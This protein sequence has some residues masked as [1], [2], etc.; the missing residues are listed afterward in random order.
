MPS[1]LNIIFAGTPDFAAQH[2]VALLNTEHKVV[3]VYCPPDKPAGRGKKLTH[4]AT[5]KIA[6]AQNIAIEQPHNLKKEADQKKL[7]DYN[8]DIV[9]V[10]AYGVLLP[11]TVLK[12]KKLGCI[13]VHGSLLPEWRV[14]AP[15]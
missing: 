2:L 3:A 5:K 13:N 12:K 6:L 11:E 1:S 9:V 8:A 10:V 7:A 15:F 4:C 14:A